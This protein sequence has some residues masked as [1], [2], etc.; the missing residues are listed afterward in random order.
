M[1]IGQLISI[2]GSKNYGHIDGSCWGPEKTRLEF[3]TGHNGRGSAVEVCIYPDHYDI[4]SRIQ[5]DNQEPPITTER[6]NI[7]S[8]ELLAFINENVPQYDPPSLKL[9]KIG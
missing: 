8:D 7:T 2:L 1:D 6:K 9:I 4:T 5:N 3:S